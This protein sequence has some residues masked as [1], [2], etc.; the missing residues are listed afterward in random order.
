VFEWICGGFFPFFLCLSLFFV[1]SLLW[2]GSDKDLVFH[3]LL[4]RTSINFMG[5]DEL[6]LMGM[7][8]I[9]S[10]YKYSFF[11]AWYYLRTLFS[12]G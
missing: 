8:V 6:K 9:I 7:M 4:L 1:L 5:T 2:S 12:N 3:V 11:P 10:K